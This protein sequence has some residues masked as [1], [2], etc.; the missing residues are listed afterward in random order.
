MAGQAPHGL[1]DP[2]ARPAAPMPGSIGPRLS[3]NSD[4]DPHRK[5]VLL[6]RSEPHFSLKPPSLA[7]SVPLHPPLPR[8]PPQLSPRQ[9]PPSPGR[10]RPKSRPTR[11]DWPG[12]GMTSRVKK[13]SG[14]AQHQVKV[15]DVS[16]RDKVKVRVSSGNEVKVSITNEV[17]VTG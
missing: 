11:M 13:R 7:H 12:A 8:P 10:Q 9:P 17:K 4:P 2:A 3:W 15:K 6:V 5:H 1:K 16:E 14:Q